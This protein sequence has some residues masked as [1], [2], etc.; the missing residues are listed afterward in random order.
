MQSDELDDLRSN[1]ESLKSRVAD[2]VAMA[3]LATSPAGEMFLS[4]LRDR[5]SDLV[6]GAVRESESY[7]LACKSIEEIFALMGRTI[8]VGEEAKLELE[9][10]GRPDNLE[11]Y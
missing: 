6:R 10:I 1:A 4:V 5:Y 8:S 9:R 11:D 3:S 7:R 2:G